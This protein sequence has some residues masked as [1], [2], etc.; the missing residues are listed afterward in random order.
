MKN[1][2]LIISFAS[3]FSFF[4]VSSY[5]GS[6]LDWNLDTLEM[7][8]GNRMT[9]LRI[10]YV[11]EN[12]NVSFK[13]N[14]LY[15]QGLGDSMLNH[16][17]L[18][19]VL[20]KEGFRV[21]AFDYSGQGGSTGSMNQTT[22]KKINQIGDRV[23]E[24]LGRGDGSSQKKYHIIG[25]S[26]GGLAAYRKA[27]VDKRNTVLS[28]ILMAPGI[29]PNYIVGEGLQSWPID[30]ISM[31]TLTRN[32]FDGVNDPHEDSIHP[33]SPI[34]APKFALNLQWTAKK[35]RKHWIVSKRIKGLVLLSG[36][37]DTYV[38]ASRTKKA[39]SRGAPHFKIKQYPLA[40]HEI[41][42]EVEEIARDVRERILN[43]LKEIA[44][45]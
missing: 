33:I 34:Y 18:F 19:E 17:P 36:S 41:D 11:E 5:A 40:L 1:L 7:Y 15:Y 38:N 44:K 16:D 29:A 9:S 45:K 27:Y 32:T 35:A 20:T 24:V 6:F 10:G 8:R 12:P 30:K 37:Q 28:V 14:I 2:I 13:G 26:T 39:L 22:I 21:I 43:F 3:A 23:I 42:N 25:W 31:R 4:S